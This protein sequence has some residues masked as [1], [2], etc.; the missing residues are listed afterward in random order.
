MRMEVHIEELVLEGFEARDRHRMRDA[1]EREL[2]R[3]LADG[4]GSVWQRLTRNIEVPE[5]GARFTLP[6]A[7]TPEGKGGLVARAVHEAVG[8]A[9]AAPSRKNRRGKV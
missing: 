9:A 5:L 3:L 1:V 8:R 7:A 6:A 2:R 4:R